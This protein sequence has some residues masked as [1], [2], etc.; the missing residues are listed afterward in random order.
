MS[1]IDA[2]SIFGAWPKKNLDLSVGTLLANMKSNGIEKSVVISAK[3]IFYSHDEGNAE[4]LKV[5][6]EHKELI[7]AATINPRG[8]APGNNLS[9]TLK[10]QGFKFIRFFPD[11]QGWPVEYSPF[12]DL[13]D[14]IEGTGLPIM[15]PCNGLGLSTVLLRI[16]GKKKI[17]VVIGS[18][19]YAHL[20]E[21]LSVM[22]KNKDFYVISKLHNTPDGIEQFVKHCGA[23]RVLF[24]SGQPVE[25]IGNSLE[26]IKNANISKADRAKILGSNTAKILKI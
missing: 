13:L 14:E 5:C 9:K 26:V 8:I 18:T 1:I 6:A 4:T 21:V 11:H 3:G 2:D 12:I 17:K 25:Y 24:G 7:P 16:I 20:S 23:E 22:K 10:K 19:G 15:F